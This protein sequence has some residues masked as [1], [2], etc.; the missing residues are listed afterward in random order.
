M[1]ELVLRHL[2]AMEGTL[3]ILQ[4]QIAAAKHA[5]QVAEVPKVSGPK[6][7]DGFAEERCARVNDDARISKASFGAPNA[8]QCVGC[9]S[10]LDL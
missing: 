9:G 6:P 1:N 7:C 3:A 4:G 8:A 10:R 5:M 2:A